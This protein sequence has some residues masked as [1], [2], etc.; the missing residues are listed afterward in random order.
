MAILTLSEKDYRALVRDKN[1]TYPE[2]YAGLHMAVTESLYSRHLGT[3]KTSEVYF[4][5]YLANRTT[6]YG[7][8]AQDI[9]TPTFNKALYSEKTG[10][11]IA[12]PIGLAR[13]TR[14]I[15]IKSLEEKG[16]INVYRCSNTLAFLA[17]LY[18]IRC[19]TILGFPVYDQ[20]KNVPIPF[21]KTR[22][23]AEDARARYEREEKI[24]EEGLPEIGRMCDRKSDTIKHRALSTE[25]ATSLSTARVARVESGLTAKQ[26]VE[27]DICNRVQSRA[28]RVAASAA[29]PAHQITK[30][31]M[32]ALLDNGRERYQQT[33]TPRALVTNKALSKL[34]AR[35]KANPPD[36]FKQFLLHT[37]ATWAGFVAQYDRIAAKRA[38]GGDPSALA[39]PF[40]RH[41]NFEDL[42][43]RYP[44]LLKVYQN[45]SG[46]AR[47]VAVD[48][49]KET[50]RKL[51][52]QVQALRQEK[53][54][55]ERLFREKPTTSAP[56]S[57][58]VAT[59]RSSAPRPTLTD[60][61][62]EQLFAE[63]GN[64]GPL[65]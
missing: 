65:E 37:M 48:E 34:R 39:H 63:M 35:L 61:E 11:Q 22:K 43:Y 55:V 28:T 51:Q 5:G 19:E 15:V 10:E 14:E 47:Q 50:I 36:D 46:P 49:D 30:L 16:F 33:G 7:K 25:K 8:L 56:A 38:K 42:A 31:E 40:A 24:L 45:A 62:V 26:L 32:Q 44:Y 53:T 21:P 29:K 17:P 41:F 54:T 57:R 18:E 20:E 12:A 52:R 60:A 23:A 58:P 2:E 4:L 64:V 3:L 9:A 6:R 27:K 1:R 13:S 59:R